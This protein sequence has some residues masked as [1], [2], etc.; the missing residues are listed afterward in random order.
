ML[1]WVGNCCSCPSGIAFRLEETIEQAGFGSADKPTQ[2]LVE[3]VCQRAG[4][5]VSKRND[6]LDAVHIVRHS[7]VFLVWHVKLLLDEPDGLV[8][9]SGSGQAFADLC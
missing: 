9:H 8:D 4:N 6:V 1:T 7:V 5:L 3:V 2:P